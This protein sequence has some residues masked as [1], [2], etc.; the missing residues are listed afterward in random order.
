MK[1]DQNWRKTNYHA[2]E[3]WWVNSPPSSGSAR[4]YRSKSVCPNCECTDHYVKEK[5]IAGGVKVGASIL[6]DSHP[7][8]SCYETHKTMYALDSALVPTLDSALQRPQGQATVG[9]AGCLLRS[10]ARVLW[11]RPDVWLRLWFNLLRWVNL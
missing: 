2:T 6:A 4:L 9:W 7:C 8:S 3:P 5:V 1:S 11:H 10:G